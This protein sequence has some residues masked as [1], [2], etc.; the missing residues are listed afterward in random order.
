VAVD[1]IPEALARELARIHDDGL[2]EAVTRAAL[3]GLGS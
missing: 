2:R 1:K 3:M